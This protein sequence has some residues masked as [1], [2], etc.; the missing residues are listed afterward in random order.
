VF[1]EHSLRLS[2]FSA[3]SESHEQDGEMLPLAIAKRR[4]TASGDPAMAF[5]TLPGLPERTLFVRSLTSGS[6]FR[7]RTMSECPNGNRFTERAGEFPR[8]K[9]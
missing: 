4:A 8:A 2:W 6:A 5:R 1:I 3:R 9:I 7:R